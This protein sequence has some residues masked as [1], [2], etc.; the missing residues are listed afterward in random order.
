MKRMKQLAAL[1]LTVCL[2]AAM[3]CTPAL[4][5]GEG[6]Y[7]VVLRHAENLAVLPHDGSVGVQVYSYAASSFTLPEA[8]TRPGF[9][10]A[11]W[12]KDG[13][14][15]QPGD[16]AELA[17]DCTFV[18]R[19]TADHPFADLAEDADY[20]YSV[21]DVYERGLM[22]GTAPN[23]FEPEGAFTRAM[24]WTVLARMAGVETEGE[25]WYAKARTW[26]MEREISDGTAPGRAMSRQEL[27][28][29]LY[30]QAGSP[31]V[32]DSRGLAAYPGADQVADWAWDAMW[33]GIQNGVIEYRQPGLD[34]GGAASRAEVAA[35]VSRVCA[36]QSK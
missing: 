16:Q 29:L 26:A 34:P 20:F 31:E 3:L 8:P 12:E 17:G 1:C 18:A 4:A 13:V 32:K 25:P 30:R 33:W 27:V 22:N 28:T 10:F 15:Y 2:A 36:L 35:A 21:I 5:A 14:V 24:M 19:W 11:G 6:T 7:K 9:S 23:A